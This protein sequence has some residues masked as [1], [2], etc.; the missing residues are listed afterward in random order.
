MP[1]LGRVLFP[2]ESSVAGG[3]HVLGI[4]LSIRVG[5]HGNLLRLD[6][7]EVCELHAIRRVDRGVLLVGCRG[8]LGLLSR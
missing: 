2:A 1:A 6:L 3:A 5:T 4:V 7:L 8:L